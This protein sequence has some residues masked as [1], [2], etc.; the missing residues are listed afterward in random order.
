MLDGPA[1][2]LDGSPRLRRLQFRAGAYPTPFWI[3][4]ETGAIVR[5]G[6][7]P[8]DVQLVAGA[9]EVLSSSPTTPAAPTNVVAAV[10]GTN[11]VD[12]TWDDNAVNED[13]YR[14]EANQGSGYAS[15][16]TGLAAGAQA[17]NDLTARPQGASVAY[18]VFA[19]NT[20]GD[21]APG[22]SNSVIPNPNPPSGNHT[23]GTLYA[24]DW[25]LPIPAGRSQGLFM[26]GP[27]R[28]LTTPPTP[29]TR[30]TA[31]P[32]A[33]GGAYMQ[34]TYSVSAGNTGGNTAAFLDLCTSSGLNLGPLF[35]DIYFLMQIWFD[36]DFNNDFADNYKLARVGNNFA[37]T[38]VGSMIVENNGQLQ[39]HW[40]NGVGVKI[41]LPT[42]F[43]LTSSLGSW[44]ALEW[45][46]QRL[47]S[48]SGRI[49]AWVNDTQVLG[50]TTTGMPGW[51]V[52]GIGGGE[53]ISLLNSC[54]QVSTARLGQFHVSEQRIFAP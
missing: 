5:V 47:S 3:R 18:R 41:S 8:A 24:E 39:W 4:T 19:V 11:D 9:I 16:I 43:D 53:F 25:S 14:I 21:S 37:S 52:A 46:V 23:P 17:H 44:L 49:E 51:T 40:E 54:V 1:V 38:L 26:S 20:L 28:S 10:A 22:Q 45:H 2:A 36:P 31:N 12:L 15:L 29:W 48:T 30:E 27:G 32:P 6:A 50:T 7:L 34:K 35:T 13:S 42:F 33:S